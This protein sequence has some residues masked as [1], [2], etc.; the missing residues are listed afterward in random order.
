[1]AAAVIL[2]KDFDSQ[3]IDDSKK[4]SHTKREY[5]EE[6]IKKSALS[7]AVAT[8]SNEKIDEINIL[9]ASFLAMHN[10]LDKL[11]I[12]PELL[13]VDGNRFHNYK[14]IK[15]DCIIKGD[16]KFMSIAAASILA[17]NYRD[18]L[19]G[20]LSAKYPGYGWESNVGYPTVKHREGIRKFGVTPYHRKS[21]TLLPQQ[22]ELF[23]HGS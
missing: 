7:W 5:L 6:E 19:M 20:E 1:M 3:M 17:K 15:H 2:P 18:K 21:F 14:T 23:E 12:V 10:A 8:V 22:L 9:N 16:G 4:L 11:E 13:L